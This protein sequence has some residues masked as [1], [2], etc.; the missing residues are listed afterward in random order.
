[1][2]AVFFIL[3]LL[4]AVISILMVYLCIE[5]I[6]VSLFLTTIAFLCA[7]GLTT[8]DWGNGGSDRQVR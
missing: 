4:I 3:L 5:T 7:Y 6:G 1:M 8:C 2:K